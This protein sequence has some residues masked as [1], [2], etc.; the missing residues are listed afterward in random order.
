MRFFV[1]HSWLFVLS[2]LGSLALIAAP[3]S[4]GSVKNV[5]GQGY[6]DYMNCPNGDT[7]YGV[8]IDF[9]AIMGRGQV[10]NGGFEL[11]NDSDT[12]KSG[13]AYSANISRSKFSITGTTYDDECAGGYPSTPVS[14]TIS[15]KCGTDVYFRYVD[16]N[17]ENGW[18]EGS[19]SCT[20]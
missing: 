15:G 1:R 8:N 6:S 17:G 4:A 2:M 5:S 10:W 9:G 11:G 3:A 13:D 7:A 19:V 16:A 14:F 12:Y 20:I 18:F